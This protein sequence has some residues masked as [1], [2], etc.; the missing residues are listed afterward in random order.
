MRREKQEPFLRFH[1]IQCV[2]LSL[3]WTPFLIYTDMH[4][5]TRISAIIILVFLISFF[6]SGF[7]RVIPFAYEH[8]IM[9]RRAS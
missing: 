3:F 9:D 4:P 1:C 8:R 5:A 2:L 6:T 7:R